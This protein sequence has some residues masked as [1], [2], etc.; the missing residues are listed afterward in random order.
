MRAWPLLV[1]A[2]VGCSGE[3]ALLATRGAPSP[4]HG[5]GPIGTFVETNP[6]AV[7]DGGPPPLDAGHFGAICGSPS[8]AA[9][10]DSV[11]GSP[12]VPENVSAAPLSGWP[13]DDGGTCGFRVSM[14][15]TTWAP[16]GGFLREVAYFVDVY[17]VVDVGPRGLKVPIV[18]LPWDSTGPRAGVFRDVHWLEDIPGAP[19]GDS[20]AATSGALTI[21]ALDGAAVRGTFDSSLT[22][23]RADGGLQGYSPWA[24][25]WF[26]AP[27]GSP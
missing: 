20:S 23:P 17:D 9:S 21:T 22:W 14:T 13:C 3:D 18:L 12:F 2:C 5:S 8:G 16:D 6:P 25:G 26:C 15:T 27:W 24:Q 1:L 19:G 7:H 11:D 10:I 4:L